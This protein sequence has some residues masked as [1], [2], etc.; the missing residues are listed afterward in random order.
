M[1]GETTSCLAC[2]VDITAKIKSNVP[3]EIVAI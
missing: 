3:C 2:G 1:K